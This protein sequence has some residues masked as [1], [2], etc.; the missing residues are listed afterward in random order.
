MARWHRLLGEDVFFLTGTDEHGLKIQ[1]AAERAGKKPKEFV[2]L[3][4]KKFKELC[5]LWNISYDRFIRTTDKG[6]EKICQKIFQKV[7]DKG[8]I[9]LGEYEGLYCT[10]CER[11][12]LE[13]DL[14]GRNCPIHKRAVEKV[15]EPSYFFRMSKYQK[16]LQDYFEENP[17]FIQPISRR[18]EIINRVKE[19]LQDL[20]VSRVSFKWGIP[21]PNDSKHIIYCWFDALLNYISAIDYGKR[22]FSKYWPADVHNV[23][24]DILWFHSVIWPCILFAADIKSPL[25]VWVHGFINTETGEKMSKSNGTVID[26]IELAKEFNI[27]SVRYF[28]L[29]EIPFGEDGF[30]SMKALAER[31]NNELANELGNLLNRTIVLI[32][33]N[34]KGKIPKAKPDRILAEKLHLEKIERLMEKNE[35]HSALAEIF[36]FISACNKYINEKEPWR[37]KGKEFDSVIYSLAD[38]IRIISILL[39]PFIPASSEKISKQLGIKAGLLKDC[40]FGLLKPGTKVKKGEI[41]FKKIELNN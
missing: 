2:D 6:H 3:Q 9:Y 39:S 26:P 11:F 38:S 36:S 15:K 1:R 34:R 28:F 10:D 25:K 5:E 30:F 12:Y 8:D 41:L 17:G 16:R 40:K 21:L 33:K 24:K 29:R 32:E 13:R 31:N 27:D 19:G 4:V 20:S 7:L 35:F 22:K 37:L 23:G 14:I 18:Q